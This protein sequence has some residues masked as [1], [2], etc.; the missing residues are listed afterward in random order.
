MSKDWRHVVSRQEL[1]VLRARAEEAASPAFSSV[2]RVERLFHA[3]ATPAVVLALL[4]YIDELE[5]RSGEK[6]EP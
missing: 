6:D 2:L 1:N 3:A 5:E 4:N